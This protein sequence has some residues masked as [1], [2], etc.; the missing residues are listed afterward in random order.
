MDDNSETRLLWEGVDMNLIDILGSA[1]SILVLLAYHFMSKESDS[2]RMF[3]Y[4]L[5]NVF[6]AVM[7]IVYTYNCS[8]YASMASNM[9]WIGIGINSIRKQLKL[10]I[11]NFINQRKKGVVDEKN[12]HFI[13]L[14]RN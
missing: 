3:N 1:G 2:E 13:T 12:N 8:A 4:Q 6:G 5:I 10:K 7:L 9:V 14:S 11:I